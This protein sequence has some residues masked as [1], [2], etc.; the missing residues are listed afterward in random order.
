MI[1]SWITITQ[2]MILEA[3]SLESDSY[4]EIIFIITFTNDNHTRSYVTSFDFLLHNY[5]LI[6]SIATYCK[7][8]ECWNLLYWENRKLSN[9]RILTLKISFEIPLG[10]R[11][12]KCNVMYLRTF[13]FFCN[14]RYSSVSIYIEHL[15]IGSFLSVYKIYGNKHEYLI[16]I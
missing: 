5:L 9:E 16:K 14:F 4:S 15:P 11:T 12:A 10:T 2:L 13:T 3:L 1:S 6:V 7:N 8:M